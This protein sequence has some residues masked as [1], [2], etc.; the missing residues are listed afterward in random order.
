MQNLEIKKQK[1][2][3]AFVIVG[4]V[5]HGK[6]TLIGRILFDTDS[7]PP[8]KIEEIKKISQ[9]LGRETNLSFL[10][11]HLQEEREQEI[12]IDTAQ[13]F[14][15]TPDRE[16]IIIDAPG[17]VEFIK[18][19]ITGASQ[20]GAAILMVDVKEGIKEQTRRHAYILSLLGIDQIIVVLNK[21]DSVDYQEEIFKKVKKEAEEFLGLIKI[22]TV[23]YIPIS[24]LIG[25]NIVKKSE[26]MNWYKGPTVLESLDSLADKSTSKEKSLI[27]PVQDVYRIDQNRIIVGRIEN[28]ELEK[29]QEIKILPD[30]K[31]TKV[32]SIEKFNEK[33]ERV[34]VGEN[35][36]LTTEDPLF[37]ERGNIICHPSDEL[38]VTDNFKANIFWMA[39]ED[40]KKEERIILKCATQEAVAI[41]EKI[42]KRINSSTF[43]VI[44]ENAEK[45]QNLE[46]GEVSIKTKKP[47]VIKKFNDL[48]ELGRFVLIR[49][50][51][52]C[53]GG[54][55]I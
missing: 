35:I 16:Y 45:L 7:L 1:E 2:K 22:N 46:V 11:D 34:S 13:T 25:D 51:N 12:T 17:H 52:T 38:I 30:G 48:P 42:E 43:S 3:L 14:F 21:M 40:F 5:D 54:I 29:G 31:T 39:K 9:S 49:N 55:I 10:L 8:D 15:K 18:N 50:E 26:K 32:K 27:I 37:I 19:M 33:P 20:A 23:Y 28:G 53:A 44:E 36:G 4:H 47:I 41:I 6:S 24:A